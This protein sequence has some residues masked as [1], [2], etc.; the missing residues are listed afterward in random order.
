MSGSA[1]RGRAAWTTFGLAGA[2]LAGVVVAVAA[3]IPGRDAPADPVVELGVMARRAGGFHVQVDVANV[4]ELTAAD[5]AV[6]AELG[7]GPET[8]SAEQTIEFLSGGERV[9]IVF[10]FA[11]DPRER[12]LAVRV[13]G[14]TRP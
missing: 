5:V 3:Q 2:V 13:A 4:G 11:H 10:V 12:G 1:P 7:E 8:E 6:V 14:F 9:S